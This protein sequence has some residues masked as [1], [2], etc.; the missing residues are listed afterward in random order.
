MS[1][2]AEGRRRWYRVNG[3]ALRPI[4]D[5]VQ[6]F[7]RTW[8]ASLDRLEDVLTEMQSTDTTDTTDTPEE[9]S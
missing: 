5:L 6:R 2:R 1:V 8:N 4:H 9:A 7:E 3:P